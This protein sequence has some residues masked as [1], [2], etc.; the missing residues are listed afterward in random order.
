V[1]ERF[2]FTALSAI[3]ARPDLY[4]VSDRFALTALSAY[5]DFHELSG[6]A[7]VVLAEV[8]L[9]SKPNESTGIN[10]SVPYDPAVIPVFLILIAES[11]NDECPEKYDVSVLCEFIEVSDMCAA[12][13]LSLYGTDESTVS[14]NNPLYPTFTILF[15]VDKLFTQ[16]LSVLYP[17]RHSENRMV[18]SIAVFIRSG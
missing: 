14:F 4:A 6:I 10:F 16:R 3:E 11:D 8:A 12:L 17:P 18:I 7:A 9:P 5:L 1:S 2:A 13:Q 15:C